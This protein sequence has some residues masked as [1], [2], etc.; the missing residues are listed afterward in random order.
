MKTFELEEQCKKINSYQH[1]TPCLF[2]PS[3]VF[4]CTPTYI[5]ADANFEEF[6]SL[7]D[8][9][10]SCQDVLGTMLK[11]VHISSCFTLK[12]DSSLVV[13]PFLFFIEAKHVLMAVLFSRSWTTTSKR[14]T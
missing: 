1:S 9:V 6:C 2:F 13:S 12:L 10:R 4:S 3:K 11:V 8:F 5:S 14:G 7:H